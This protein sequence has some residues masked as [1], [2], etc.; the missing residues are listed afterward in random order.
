MA[1]EAPENAPILDGRSFVRACYHVGV[2]M[3]AFDQGEG[4]Y[5]LWLTEC[6]AVG[7]WIG[8]EDVDAHNLVIRTRSQIFAVG[9]KAHGM[10]CA[11]VMAHGG[12]LPWLVVIGIIAMVDGFGRPYPDVSVCDTLH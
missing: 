11:R 3:L 1:D 6:C 7:G 4:L 12:E 9:G 2:R 10:D 8:I 5:G